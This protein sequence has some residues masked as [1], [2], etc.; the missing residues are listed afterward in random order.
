[1]PSFLIFV[2]PG[3]AKLR[4]EELRQTSG[5]A[6]GVPRHPHS[7]PLLPVSQRHGES[8]LFFI[9][10]T[11]LSGLAPGHSEGRYLSERHSAEHLNTDLTP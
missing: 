6:E 8:Q 4:D 9:C 10:K 2:G 1:L 7:I 3:D 11:F 5:L